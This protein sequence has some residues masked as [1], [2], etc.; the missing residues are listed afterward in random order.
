MESKQDAI[1]S[2]RRAGVIL[3]D[4]LFN[5]QVFYKTLGWLNERYDFLASVFVAYPASEE[6][7]DAYFS[8]L[9]K[10]K[11]KWSPALCALLYQNGKWTLGLGISALEEEL[12]EADRGGLQALVEQTERIRE[13]VGAD[14]KTFA[15]ILPGILNRRKITEKNTEAEVTVHAVLK[16]K[17]IVEEKEDLP[18]DAPIIVLG[19][20]GYIGS[21]LMDA[22][23]EEKV[24][25]VEKASTGGDWP[26]HRRIFR[27][28]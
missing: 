6:Y 1:N 24:Y 16:A 12:R 17:E 23:P 7:A 15:G 8:Q 21:R 11:R 18:S 28:S 2:L 3:L 25:S 14:Y 27:V 13:T 26:I 10:Q 9:I 4:L 20:N 5:H 22:L 19:G